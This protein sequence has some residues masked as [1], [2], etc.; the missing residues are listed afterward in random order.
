[1]ESYVL[2]RAVGNATVI[3]VPQAALRAL[4]WH[5]GDRVK[6]TTDPASGSFRVEV[7]EP[8]YRVL[9]SVDNSVERA[10]GVGSEA[11]SGDPPAAGDQ[12]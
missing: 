2:L 6:V 9:R 1:M 4:G 8:C 3:T 7:T 12:L 11:A 10:E 5:R